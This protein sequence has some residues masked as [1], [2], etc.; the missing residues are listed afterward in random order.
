[1]DMVYV[2]CRWV[3]LKIYIRTTEFCKI[4]DLIVRQ[5][6]ALKENQKTRFNHKTL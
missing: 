5:A 4:K 1:M 6:F 2:F 3:Y